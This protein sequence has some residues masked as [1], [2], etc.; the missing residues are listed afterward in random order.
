MSVSKECWVAPKGSLLAL[1]RR[2]RLA[3]LLPRIDVFRACGSEF[4]PSRRSLLPRL[5][6]SWPAGVLACP[7]PPLSG[8]CRH[9]RVSPFLRL[10]FQNIADLESGQETQRWPNPAPHFVDERC[11]TPEVPCAS[12]SNHLQSLR[13]KFSSMKNNVGGLVSTFLEDGNEDFGAGPPVWS[14]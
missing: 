1:L 2:E 3:L 5:P 14:L 4:S 8:V 13:E 10:A 6:G 11:P 12:A 9:G 7:D